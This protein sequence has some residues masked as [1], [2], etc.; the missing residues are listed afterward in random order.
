M[1][2]T[3]PVTTALGLAGRPLCEQAHRPRVL[4]PVPTLLCTRGFLHPSYITGNI[5]GF[6]YVAVPKACKKKKT[7]ENVNLRKHLQP[8]QPR[9]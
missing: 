3:S 7:T 1:S 6:A 9:R 4:C 8:R 5:A 2:L